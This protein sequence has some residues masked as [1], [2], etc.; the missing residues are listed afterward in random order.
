MIKGAS[1]TREKKGVESTCDEAFYHFFSG[2][3]WK[4][5]IPEPPESREIVSVSVTTE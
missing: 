4:G 2:R 3:K 1:Q 5:R